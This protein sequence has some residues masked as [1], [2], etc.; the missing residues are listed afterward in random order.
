MQAQEAFEF[1]CKFLEKSDLEKA[2]QAFQLALKL[3]PKF[4]E[5][6]NGLGV[7]YA[8]RGKCPQALLHCAKAIELDPDEPEFYRSRAY[9]YLKMDDFR[10]AQL[11][12]LKA[13]RLEEARKSAEAVQAEPAETPAG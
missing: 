10:A 1:G 11:D 6:H 4:A 2:E 5:A 9:I 3:D 8:L 7:V 13:L 12:L